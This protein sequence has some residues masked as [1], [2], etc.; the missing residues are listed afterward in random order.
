[1]GDIREVCR[2]KGN[3]DTTTNYSSDSHCEFMWGFGIFTGPISSFGTS[4]FNKAVDVLTELIQNRR[5][6]ASN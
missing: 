3:G 6:S 4:N 1:M 2:Y 5:S